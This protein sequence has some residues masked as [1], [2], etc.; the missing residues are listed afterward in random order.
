MPVLRTTP[1]ATLRQRG[2]E[3]WG[4]TKGVYLGEGPGGRRGV[5]ADMT[6]GVS[7]LLSGQGGI[8]RT[9]LAGAAAKQ[10]KGMRRVWESGKRVE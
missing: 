6:R 8:D 1:K 10:D 7:A 4:E 3:V 2:K 5:L 9:T